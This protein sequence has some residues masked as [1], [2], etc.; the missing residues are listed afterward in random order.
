MTRW[1]ASYIVVSED[2]Y[3]VQHGPRRVTPANDERCA[4][5]AESTSTA[6]SRKPMALPGALVYE[7]YGLTEAEIRI[8]EGGF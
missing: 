2:S 4:N 8:V 6:V 5:T 7:L 3:I 1:V